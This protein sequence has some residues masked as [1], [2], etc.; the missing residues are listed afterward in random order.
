MTF[1]YLKLI[2]PKNTL[3]VVISMQWMLFIEKKIYLKKNRIGN[4]RKQNRWS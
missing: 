4:Q 1:Y 3:A 2:P